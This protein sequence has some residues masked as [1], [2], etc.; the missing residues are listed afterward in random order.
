MAKILSRLIRPCI[1]MFSSLI[2]CLYILRGCKNMGAWCYVIKAG[3]SNWKSCSIWWILI[4]IHWFFSLSCLKLYSAPTMK[5]IGELKFY[6]FLTSPTVQL[7]QN[8]NCLQAR[9]LGIG[10]IGPRVYISKYVFWYFEA[11][12]MVINISKM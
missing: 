4:K 7:P 3:I 6:H 5:C 12:Y 1:R 9:N 11:I 8:P 10:S 2:K